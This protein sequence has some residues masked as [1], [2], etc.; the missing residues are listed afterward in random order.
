MLGVPE[1]RVWELLARG[2][3][4]GTPD[5]DSM[6]VFLKA[7]QEVAPSS[8]AAAAS[9]REQGSAMMGE[10]SAFRE[11]LTEF[12]NLTERYG[13]ALLALGEARGE[14]AG[15][16]SRIELLESRAGLRLTGSSR[17]PIAWEPEPVAPTFQ[18]PD[19]PADLR[20]P[21]TPASAAAEAAPR[22]R[23]KPT[24]VPR[25]ARKAPAQRRAVAGIA[26]ALARAE[27]PA[28]PALPEGA[29]R[30]GLAAPGATPASADVSDSPYSTDVVEPD[31][32]ADGDF[33]WLEA[34][35]RE[36]AGQE[37][38]G[39]EATVLSPVTA[40]VA[41]DEAPDDAP[42]KEAAPPIDAYLGEEIT[43]LDAA[44]PG[45]A[46]APVPVDRESEA[47]APADPVVSFRPP[48][49]GTLS[50]TEEELAQ[51]VADEGW[52]PSEVD[53]IRGLIG[54]EVPPID[55]PGGDELDAA[56]AALDA[57]A[58][59]GEWS[60]PH[61]DLPPPVESGADD[62]AEAEP[63]PTVFAEAV[64][65]FEAEPE[66]TA[67]MSEVAEVRETAEEEPM[68]P[69][70]PA[71]FVPTGPAPQ[72][73]PVTRP[74]TNEPSWLRGRRGPAATA[75]RTLRRLLPG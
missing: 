52:G 36:A 75:F 61:V 6:R 11:L 60:K 15:L 9:P 37:V 23:A 55:L 20:Q 74:V 43:E 45:Y 22:R 69:P 25:P 47:E 68:P 26:E 8:R 62:S 50:L 10:A 40:H 13:Q 48:Q 7:S 59:E 64:E 54:A 14:V 19:V 67:W 32:F 73:P 24:A 3:L 1:G 51:L 63:G 49:P 29:P 4:G 38:T 18:V 21:A 66:R 16:R 39:P 30:S 70:S 12:R 41:P 71:A 56:L 53:T 17:E 33:A 46:E 57:P 28:S 35:D 5:G 2:V 27:D 44:P 72:P 58:T 34:A 42:D 65:P 31:W